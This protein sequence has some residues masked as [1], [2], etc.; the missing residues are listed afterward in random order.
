VVGELQVKIWELGL[1][2]G[3]GR[4]VRSCRLGCRRLGCRVR[5]LG[6]V[7]LGVRG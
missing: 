1:R 4:R 5:S 2:L 7:G 3:L 6:V